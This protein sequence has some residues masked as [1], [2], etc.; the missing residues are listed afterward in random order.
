ML[1]GLHGLCKKALLTLG[2]MP[3]QY[4]CVGNKGTTCIERTT[5]LAARAVNRLDFLWSVEELVG[6]RLQVATTCRQRLQVATA[7][8][9]L[10]GAGEGW[11]AEESCALAYAFKNYPGTQFPIAPPWL[12]RKRKSV[13]ACFMPTE[14]WLRPPAPASQGRL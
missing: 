10:R 2:F 6:N 1:P 4:V 3:T 13:D 7:A 12:D 8:G 14:T 5:A 9:V 11:R